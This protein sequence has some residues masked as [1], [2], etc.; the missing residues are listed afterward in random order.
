VEYPILSA[1]NCVSD[2]RENVNVV[3]V[4]NLPYVGHKRYEVQPLKQCIPQTETDYSSAQTDQCS[5]SVTLDSPP[6]KGKRK[7]KSN[8]LKVVRLSD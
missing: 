7:E 4:G 2:S 1:Q 6:P 8:L 3:K 5:G